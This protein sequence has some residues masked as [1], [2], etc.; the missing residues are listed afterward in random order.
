MPLL[1]AIPSVPSIVPVAVL[2]TAI[3]EPITVAVGLLT[4]LPGWNWKLVPAARMVWPCGVTIWPPFCTVSASSMTVPPDW[5]AAGAVVVICAPGSTMMAVLAVAPVKVGAMTLP[6]PTEPYS[7]KPLI[8]PLLSLVSCD[9]AIAAVEATSEP[10]LSCEPAPNSTPKG[11]RMK[12][13]P[14]ALIWP[15]IVL[16]LASGSW[17]ELIA[18]QVLASEPPALWL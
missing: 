18:T 4:E 3:S 1:V 6:A 10:R 14:G 16:G 13:L 5:L 17:M 2:V 7:A 12:I 15:R 8:R 11:L 9:C